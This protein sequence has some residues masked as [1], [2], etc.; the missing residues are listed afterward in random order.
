MEEIGK[1]LCFYQGRYVPVDSLLKKAGSTG[2]ESAI[3]ALE[4]HA[5]HTKDL[6]LWF[7]AFQIR[8]D[9]KKPP[10]ADISSPIST[11]TM[12]NEVLCML[13][14]QLSILE[15]QDLL[16]GS[17]ADLHAFSPFNQRKDWVPV[18]LVLMFDLKLDYSYKRITELAGEITPDGCCKIGSLMTNFSKYAVRDSHYSTW[19]KSELDD[20]SRQLCTH[21]L[22]IIK[23]RILLFY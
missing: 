13:Y 9:W 21:F 10:H 17:V 1:S 16:H 14:N 19:P 3:K 20:R 4:I 12:T 18:I 5:Y 11:Q 23:Q 7:R 2:D 6:T 15:Q 22:E 8:C